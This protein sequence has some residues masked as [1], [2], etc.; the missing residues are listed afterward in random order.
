M[1]KGAFEGGN[2][3]KEA[4]F[5]KPMTGRYVSLEALNNQEGTTRACVAE[6]YLLDQNGNRISREDWK[7]VYADSEETDKGNCMAEKAYDLQ[8]ST[9]WS[10]V[11]G[12]QF[13]HTIIIDLG[14]EYTLTAIQYLPR[15][16]S[17]VPGC[18]KDYQ[19]KISKD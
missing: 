2:G 7:V 15:M 3:W 12:K 13:P 9:Y 10:T 18:I 5:S 16:E 14:K 17:N 6:L 1:E 11:S 19:I 8:E 4:K